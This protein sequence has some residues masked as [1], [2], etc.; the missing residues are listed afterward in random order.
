VSRADREVES[1]IRER[2][3]ARFPADGVIGE[4]QGGRPGNRV[5]ITDPIDGTANFL[6]GIPYWSMTLAFVES[7][8]PLIG[9]TY[10]PV[11][12]ELFAA[13]AGGGAR[14]DGRPIEVSRA[15][16]PEEACVA[17]SF[18]FRTPVPDYVRAV[19]RLLAAG[20]DHRRLGSAALSLA[21]LADGR[22]DAAFTLYTHSW[23]V[24][25][26]LLL[27]REA[28][29]KVTEFPD[30]LLASASAAAATPGIAEEIA[31][32]TGIPVAV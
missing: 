13:L 19:E 26:G 30:D 9:L 21:H 20:F 31:A 14:L 27:V 25:S 8:R 32:C 5:W 1:L 11:H 18:A 16:S 6:R 7:G 10:D 23:D 17:L 2:L 3:A 28:G 29:G 24:L 12:N 15:S 4:E 22:L